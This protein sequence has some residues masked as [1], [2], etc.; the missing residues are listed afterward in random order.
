[1]TIFKILICFLFLLQLFSM[2][3]QIVFMYFQFM[4]L[5]LDLIELLLIIRRL[6]FKF[7]KFK[8]KI[9]M[10]SQYIFVLI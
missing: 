3:L 4:V 7:G 8:L 5:L 6:G 10:F 2:L 9:A 1:M